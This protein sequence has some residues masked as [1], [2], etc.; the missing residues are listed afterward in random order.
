MCFDRNFDDADGVRSRGKQDLKKQYP[1]FFISKKGVGGMSGIIFFRTKDLM[2]IKE[3]Y[4]S[5]GATMWLEQ[6]DCVIL[7]HSNLLLGF[8]KS[9]A[10]EKN[11]VITFFYRTK[12]EVDLAYSELREIALATP[13]E[14]EKYRIYHFFAK[15]PENRTIEFQCF[16]HPLQPYQDGEELLKNRR[17]IRYFENRDVPDEVLWRIF[18]VCRFSPTAKNSQSYYF[19]V[20]RDKKTLELLASLRGRSSAPL[21]RAP[22][23]VAICSDP[24]LSMSHVQDGCIAAYHFILTSWLH[25]LGTCWIADMDRL[26][27]KKA[28]DVPKEHYVATVTPV[29]YPAKIP[30]TPSRRKAEEMVKF[31][32]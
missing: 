29:G 32:G 10:C 25:D 16:L 27:V 12:E 11:G 2:K 22:I 1:K 19:V 23:A 15:D 4:L 8:C 6:G 14:N 13:K 20:I 21:S 24:E 9:E 28:I 7:K 5:I 26:E 3:F 17:S 18:E 31:V 30:E